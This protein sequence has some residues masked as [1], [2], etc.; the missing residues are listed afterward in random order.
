[1][2]VGPVL[3]GSIRPP[4]AHGGR[5]RGSGP[6]GPLARGRD[7][8]GV[9]GDRGGARTCAA[10]VCVVGDGFNTRRP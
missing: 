6:R 7:T 3:L 4:A 1:M 9:A 10:H 8:R 5:W 2:A